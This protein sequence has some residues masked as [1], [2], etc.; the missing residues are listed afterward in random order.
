VLAAGLGPMIEDLGDREG[1]LRLRVIA[2]LVSDEHYMGM[3]Q[4][5]MW[6]LP[7]LGRSTAFL[8]AGLGFLPEALREERIVLATG[9]GVRAF[10]DQ[11]RLV[12]STAPNRTPLGTETFAAHLLVL[13]RVLLEAPPPPDT[14]T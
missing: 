12:D 4:A 11:A 9:F 13:L 8:A 3:T 2:N 14:G 10:A 5:L 1:R 7:G 6:Q